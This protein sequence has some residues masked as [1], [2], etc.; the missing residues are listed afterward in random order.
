MIILESLRN[1]EI[2]LYSFCYPHWSTEVNEISV[3]P[4]TRGLPLVTYIFLEIHG[5]VA[6]DIEELVFIF[7]GKRILAG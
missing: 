5:S 6:N 1:F 7:Q 3:N 2:D 4:R